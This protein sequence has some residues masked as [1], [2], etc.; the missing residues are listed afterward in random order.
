MN[1]IEAVVT[2]FDLEVQ[3]QF[4][5]SDAFTYT[6]SDGTNTSAAATVTI[7]VQDDSP[8]SE[9]VAVADSYTVDEDQSLIID[10][11]GGVL[12]NDTDADNDSLTAAGRT[13][14]SNGT[15]TLATDG[16]FT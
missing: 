9:P 14:A 2:K 12:G 7:T 4:T 15:L 10:A 11:V 16:S 13:T 8:N 1:F 6:A 5:G 3:F